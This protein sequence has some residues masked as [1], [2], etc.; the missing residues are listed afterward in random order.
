MIEKIIE[1]YEEFEI[2][3]ERNKM[4]A[5]DFERREIERWQ[6][7]E[8]DRDEKY[9]LFTFV[10]LSR[11]DFE[12]LESKSFSKLLSLIGIEN[13]LNKGNVFPK[14][15]QQLDIQKS[16]E[17]IQEIK[18]IYAFAEQKDIEEKFNQNDIFDKSLIKKI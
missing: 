15:L 2:D 5:T 6:Q 11:K 16:K 10:P 7:R 4:I 13:S 8:N 12:I 14:I 9:S 1:E 3:F 17:F 18:S